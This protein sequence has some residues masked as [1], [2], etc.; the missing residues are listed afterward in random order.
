LQD[1][2]GVMFQR[3]RAAEPIR[4]GELADQKHG[5][6]GAAG[7]LVELEQARVLPHRG[8]GGGVALNR[9]DDNEFGTEVASMRIENVAQQEV[10]QLL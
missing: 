1:D 4:F 5:D 3:A 6:T 2:I 8:A 9:I 7:E 10:G